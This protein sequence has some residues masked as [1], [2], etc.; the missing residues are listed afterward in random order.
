M[1][2]NKCSEILNK[3]TFEEEQ[4]HGYKAR[5]IKNA[6]ADATIAIAVNFNSPGERLT[7]SSVL[8]QRKLYIHI[9]VSDEFPN[10]ETIVNG[11]IDSLNSYNVKTLNVAGN[12]I[13][14]VKGKYNQVG[15]D[16]FVY[17]LLK[18]IVK[19]DRL[20]TKIIHIRTGGQTGF[21]EA[22]A[23]AGLK[24][25]IPTTVLAPN[26]WLF[27]DISGNDISDEKQFKERFEIK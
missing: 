12:S 18:A 17:E 22:G 15:I 1:I 7:K 26:G 8:S 10:I 5:T 6:S 19:S 25:G 9:D 21:D 2:D 4:T 16:L 13:C 14:S 3:I 11:I 24:L 23:K 27:R 20:K